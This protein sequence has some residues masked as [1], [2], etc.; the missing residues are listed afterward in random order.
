MTGNSDRRP[1]APRA[2]SAQ[3]VRR[4]GFTL[5]ELLVA[6]T[7]FA[8]L[9]TSV[10]SIFMVAQRAQ[11]SAAALQLLQ[12]DGRFIMTK[13]ANEFQNGGAIDYAYY[14]EY[15]AEHF[16]GLVNGRP[17]AATGGS[18]AETPV[19]AIALDAS[20]TH[21]YYQ[22]P[23]GEGETYC[24]FAVNQMDPK[25]VSCLVMEV[26]ENGVAS[27][28]GPARVSSE[29]MI[30]TNTAFFIA[31]TQDPFDRDEL[32]GDYRSK[33]QPRVTI[34]MTETAHIRGIRDPRGATLRLQTTL[35]SRQ[36][37]R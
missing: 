18:A 21:V 26:W 23:E 11:R 3:P 24:K 13:L 1:G 17:F 32:S 12:A 33:I 34:S 9:L 10:I 37:K 15:G 19:L 2:L 22:S 6:T 25:D 29:G 20:R 31:P 5:I 27:T 4:S 28:N 7:I 14:S 36:Y 35:S 8:V 30:I 16:A